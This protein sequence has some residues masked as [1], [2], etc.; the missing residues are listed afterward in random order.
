MPVL[1]H[2]IYWY[3]VIFAFKFLRIIFCKTQT[4]SNILAKTAIYYRITSVAVGSPE[5]RVE[6]CITLSSF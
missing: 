1:R 2:K 4:D 5:E 3:D 6:Y